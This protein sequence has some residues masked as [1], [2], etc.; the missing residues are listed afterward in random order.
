M[1]MPIS[2]PTRLAWSS[3]RRTCLAAMTPSGTPTPT[4]NIIAAMVSSIVAGNRSRSSVVI[5]RW[6]SMLTPKSPLEHRCRYLPYCTTS[7]RS[8]P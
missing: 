8:R 5:G 6:L 7:G 3:G 1:L 2:D 4:A